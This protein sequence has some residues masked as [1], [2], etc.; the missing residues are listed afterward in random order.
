[1]VDVSILIVCYRSRDL[2]LQCL[3]GVDLYTRGCTYEVLLVDCS[4]DGTADLVRESYPRTRIIENTQNLGFG[5]GNNLLAEHATGR[6]LVLLNPDVVVNDD[7]IGELY[8]TAMAWPD[9]G[10]VGGRC[11]LPTGARDPGS[12]QFIPTLFRLAIAAMGGAR[13]LNGALAETATE[14]ATVETLSG[15]F[16]LVRSEAWHEA[17]GFDSSFFMYS[18]ELDLCQR[19]KQQGWL[20]VM[21]PRA[22][23]IHLVGGG[24]GQNP[25]RILMLTTSRMHFF[26]KFWRPWQVITGGALLWIHALIRVLLAFLGRIFLGKIRA[27]RLKNAYGGIVLHPRNWWNGFQKF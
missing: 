15:A 20:I 27:D 6:F 8:R 12:K 21:T 26:R 19:I 7:A 17:Q 16:M 10:A 3:K 14:A 5:R 23:I 4:N 11:R 24:D 1:M 18:E 22:E 2:I 13:F 25:K 9:A